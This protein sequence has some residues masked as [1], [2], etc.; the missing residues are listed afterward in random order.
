MESTLAGIAIVRQY[1][2]DLPTIEA[3]GSEL[4]QV[5]T[6]LIDNAAAAVRASEDADGRIF[7]RASTTRDEIVV[8]VEDDGV[9]IPPDHQE[10]VFDAFFTT[11]PP[12]SGTG[13][14]LDICS[15]VVVEHGG[16]LT[17]VHS[18]QGRTVFRV[19]LPLD[20]RARG[21]GDD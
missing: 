10:R 15:R 1:D 13:L 9:G 5:W 21:D 8:E 20:T 2:S 3:L 14:G 17:L 16:S 7:V 6:H 12:G 19:A 18:E 4:N 11:K